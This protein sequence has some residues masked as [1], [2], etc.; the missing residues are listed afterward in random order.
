[1]SRKTKRSRAT[2]KEI[3][4]RRDALYDIVQAGKPM[5]I[6]QVYYQASVHGIVAKTEKAYKTV[7]IAELTNMRRA[8][9][10][11][12]D[13][14]TDNTRWP[15]KPR[16]YRTIAD[17]L[18]D[19]AENYRKSL[20]ADMDCYVEVWLEKDALAGVLLPVTA[21]FDVPLM[22]SRGYASLSFLHNAAE[23]IK[24]IAEPTHIYHLGDYDPSGVNAGEKIEETLREMAPDADITFMRLAVTPEQ[25]EAWKLP[26]RRTKPKDTRAKRFGSKV[27]VELDAIEPNM[28]RRLVREA[29]ER[30]MPPIQ[31]ADLLLIEEEERQRLRRMVDNMPS[32]DDAPPPPRHR[33][34]QPTMVAKRTRQSTMVA[35]RT[36]Q[37]T[38]E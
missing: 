2:N 14:I 24:G 20:W 26:T 5:T 11:P 16:T 22:V 29:I 38:R 12:Y 1:M 37:S 7:I 31:Y 27:S 19:T 23:T 17:A 13:W 30:H 35:K 10:I 25:I 36:R 18:A 8:G 34:R 4:A 21:T 33:T 28:L 6:R 32:D 15:R 9:I 3:A